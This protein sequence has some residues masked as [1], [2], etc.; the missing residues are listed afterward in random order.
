MIQTAPF[1]KN[2]QKAGA[3]CIDQQRWLGDREVLRLPARAIAHGNTHNVF[4]RYFVNASADVIAIGSLR[5]R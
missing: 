1:S 4:A 2:R 5:G 3:E